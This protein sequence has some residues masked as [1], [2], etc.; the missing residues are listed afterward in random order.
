MKTIR[1]MVTRA[2][3]PMALMICVAVPAWAKHAPAEVLG[4]HPG[5]TD[6]EVQHRLEKIGEVVR[7]KD[8]AKQTWKL[9]DPRYGYLILRYDENWKMHWVTAF[10]RE[11]GRRV[12]YRDLGDLSTA[13][14]SGQYFY[15]W[16][17]PARSGSESW[18]LVARGGD[19]KYLDSVSMLAGPMKQALIVPAH[20]ETKEEGEPKDDD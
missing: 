6:A 20:T 17:V 7:G 10:A 5:M 2:V 13:T 14:L 4:L 16:S 1:S 19:P 15:T 3:L 8:R 12:R 11:G 18:S 9:R